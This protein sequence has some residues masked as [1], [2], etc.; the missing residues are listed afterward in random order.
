M[1]IPYHT[2]ISPFCLF[3]FSQV[4]LVVPTEVLQFFP[5]YLSLIMAV[6]LAVCITHTIMA[7]YLYPGALALVNFAP[8]LLNIR[9]AGIIVGLLS[10]LACM[11]LNDTLLYDRWVYYSG[12]AAGGLTGV[13]LS[14]YYVVRYRRLPL[15]GLYRLTHALRFCGFNLPAFMAITAGYGSFAAAGVLKATG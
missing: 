2:N 1:A 11:G 14:D 10:V 6:C 9:L 8:P 5:K 15:E 12:L 4:L 3:L 7:S 13:I